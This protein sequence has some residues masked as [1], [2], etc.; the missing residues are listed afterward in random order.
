MTRPD[1]APRSIAMYPCDMPA[2]VL[3][4]SAAI[5]A[6][7]GFAVRTTFTIC[8]QRCCQPSQ[9]V[10]GEC[11]ARHCGSRHEFPGDRHACGLPSESMPPTAPHGRSTC[12]ALI[13]IASLGG[14]HYSSATHRLLAA[15]VVACRTTLLSNW[16]L[17]DGSC[18]NT[19]RAGLARGRRADDAAR[20]RD[21]TSVRRLRIR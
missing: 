9:Q 7:Y 20:S 13:C 14:C 3:H 1:S 12:R 18:D 10:D 8:C 17:Y 16:Q 11:T 15:P 2:M 19:S 4:E 6:A 5:N 21:S